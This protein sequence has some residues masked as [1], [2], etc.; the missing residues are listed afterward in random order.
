MTVGFFVICGG[1][2]DTLPFRIK[3]SEMNK[4]I[5]IIFFMAQL[6]DFKTLKL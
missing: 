6:N 3:Y 2:S 1:A 5:Q 4:I